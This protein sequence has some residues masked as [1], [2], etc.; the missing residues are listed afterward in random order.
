MPKTEAEQEKAEQEEEE[1]KGDE[2]HSGKE[3]KDAV[4]DDQHEDGLYYFNR[5]ENVYKVFDPESK[6]WSSQADK[7]TDE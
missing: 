3:G 5:E 7:P 1:R 4:V 6:S 2:Q